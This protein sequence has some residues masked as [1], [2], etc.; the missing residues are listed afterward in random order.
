MLP[1]VFGGR[2]IAS[3]IGH[4]D[5]H[6]FL[7]FLVE[8]VVSHAEDAGRSSTGLAEASDGA[9]FK[10]RPAAP[11]LR[12]PLRAVY[13][14]ELTC[15]AC[16][17]RSSRQTLSVFNISVPLPDPQCTVCTLEDCL[18]LYHGAE[19]IDGVNCMQCTLKR[20]F[21]AT[22][23]DVS[24]PGSSDEPFAA[25]V[26]RLL[27]IIERMQPHVQQEMLQQHKLDRNMLQSG[28]TTQYVP[29]QHV[30]QRFHKQLGLARLPA[31]LCIHINRF[32]EEC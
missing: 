20:D 16:L 24:A 4:Q 32:A 5:A 31:T 6:E 28:T 8:L 25:R 18:A 26:P 27:S 23:S 21:T 19:V 13:T 3:D 17:S 7:Q 2:G 9:S 10:A 12:N 11:R 1:A 29:E 14:S 15:T 30:Q 22:M